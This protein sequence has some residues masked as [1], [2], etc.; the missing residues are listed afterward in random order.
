MGTL[1]KHNF[2]IFRAIMIDDTFPVMVTVLINLE[3]REGNRDE[4]NLSVIEYLP[5]LLSL[6]E[7]R[8]H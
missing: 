7:I 5:I 4:A 1:I 3:K 2:K 6:W 8:M